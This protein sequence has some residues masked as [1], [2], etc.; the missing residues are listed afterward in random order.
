MRI[1][2]IKKEIRSKESITSK[3][4]Q[5]GT[6]G[7]NERKRLGRHKFVE[8]DVDVKLSEEL[9]GSLRELTQDGNLLR[10]RFKSF[11][12]RHIIE[13]RNPVVPHRKYKRKIV[14]KRSYKNASTDKRTQGKR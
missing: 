5:S 14:V 9:T 7:K 3:E 2:S 4:D 13:P 8:Q 10:D 12:R 1:K 6:H 11:Q